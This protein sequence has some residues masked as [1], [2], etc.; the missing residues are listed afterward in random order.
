LDNDLSEVIRVPRPREESLVT[1]S[2]PVGISAPEKIFLNI[3]NTL[4]SEANG[5]QHHARNISSGPKGRLGKSGDIWRVQHRDWER[6]SPDPD[7]LE[8]P[9]AQEREEFI[10]LV[11]KAIIFSSLQDSEQQEGREAQSPYHDEE[12][13]NDLARI[14]MAAECK[15][16]DREDHKVGSTSEV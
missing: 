11:V 12:R 2:R 7:H 4:H 5:I 1:D 15:G 14:M 9:E 13:Y 6:D 10:S 16:N 8:Y 3:A